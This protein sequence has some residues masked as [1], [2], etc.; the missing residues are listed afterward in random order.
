MPW[1]LLLL[2]FLGHHARALTQ[3]QIQACANSVDIENFDTEP[4]YS[5]TDTSGYSVSY[6]YSSTLCYT[7]GQVPVI[8]IYL[9]DLDSSTTY[10]CPVSQFG[11]SGVLSSTC[12]TTKGTIA[13]AAENGDPDWGIFL[14]LGAKPTFY[15]IENDFTVDYVDGS[16][17]SGG[18]RKRRRAL[19]DALE[20]GLPV[21]KPSLLEVKR[22]C[23][24][25]F[26][27]CRA[28]SAAGFE[29]VDT[30]SDVS[31]CGACPFSPETQDCTSISGS[32]EVECQLGQCVVLS[33]DKYH[34]LSQDGRS[35]E[36]NGKQKRSIYT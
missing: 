13:T 35:C 9:E 2:A 11:T 31:A 32:N 22:R 19:Q 14:R 6:T 5:T 3:S 4:T 33:C 24:G 25:G 7:N 17:A 1:L 10:S 8:S 30:M 26:S 12:S 16:T 29:C 23:P 21:P 20:R 18:S 28:E 34:E 27:F 15:T 36:P